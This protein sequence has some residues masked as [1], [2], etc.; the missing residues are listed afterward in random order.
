MSRMPLVAAAGLLSLAPAVA[1]AQAPVDDFARGRE[2]RLAGRSAEAAEA[3]ERAA[4]AQPQDADIW[5]NLGLAYA[6]AKRFDKADAALDRALALAPSYTDVQIARARIALFRGDAAEAERRLQ[7]A[8]QAQAPTPDA[9]QLRDQIAAALREGE[10]PWRFDASVS[11]AR[12]S[13]PL[14]DSTLATLALSRRLTSGVTLGG[15]TEYVRQF[16][17][18][19]LYVEGFAANR[20]GYLAL[21]GAPDADFRPE[22]AVRAGLAG[23]RWSISEG[24]TVQL[25]LD[26]SWARYPVGDVRSLHPVATLA[27][28]EG[29]TLQARWINV[30]DEQ[31]EYRDGYALGLGW[32]VA[33]RLRASLGW[34]DAPES[35]QGV[36]T[37]LQAVSAGLQYDFGS[38][39][40]RIG[41]AHEMR[42]AYDRDE[43][44]LA[45]SRRF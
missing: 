35:T 14:P 30:L 18:T 37:P 20:L 31:D 38:A 44:T 12:V 5:L 23:K 19:D 28:G 24:W 15:S 27:R 21:G 1:L 41:G 2:L 13:G 7:P 16:G 33:P 39:V 32:Q 40:V 26:G 11:R 34:A 17:R 43:L 22:I 36:T 29:F 42:P 4:S 45:V 6:A 9:V 10:M 8:L 3:L 25:G